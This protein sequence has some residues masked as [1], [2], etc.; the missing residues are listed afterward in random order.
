MNVPLNI[1]ETVKVFDLVRNDTP[2]VIHIENPEIPVSYNILNEEELL[3][4]DPS[5]M[6]I[7]KQ[8]SKDYI[9]AGRRY[10]LAIRSEV[11]CNGALIYPIEEQRREIPV[12][13]PRMIPQPPSIENRRVI[14][15]S[16]I[17]EN[18]ENFEMKKGSTYM[19]IIIALVIIIIIAAAIVYFK[20]SP[21]SEKTLEDT[22]ST[23][24]FNHM[25]F[26]YNMF[27]AEN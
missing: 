27:N 11:P 15:Q 19:K 18:I 21:S 17:H 2:I 25:N 4:I 22:G 10:F 23:S 1:S 7:I 16:S 12:E 5:R 20:Q 3:E 13:Q 26:L 6:K 14:P 24:M 9:P 8:F